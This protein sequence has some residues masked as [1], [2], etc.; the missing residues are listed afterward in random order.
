MW[1]YFATFL[2]FKFEEKAD[3]A[4]QLEQ[5]ITE[6][7]DQHRR[8]KEHA[9]NVIA[10]Q[11][12]QQRQL[13]RQIDRVDKL[14]V[15]ARQA[16]QMADKAAR[17]GDAAKAEEYTRAAETI[18][19]QL[20]EAE[21][22]VESMRSGLLAATAAAD[23]AKGAVS[24]NGLVLQKKLAEKQQLLSRLEQARMQEQMNKA[25][26]SLS[27]TVGQDVPSMD[28]VRDKIDQRFA[29]AK[30]MSEL[31]ETSVESRMLE[32]EAAATNA[33]AQSRLEEIRASLGIAPSEEVVEESSSG[34]VGDVL[35]DGQ[36]TQVATATQ[37]GV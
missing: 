10:G 27:E 4:I 21:S 3:P 16:V 28:E 30:G 26:A 33:G 20:I 8:L 1:R 14:Q 24:T 18:A 13:D 25:M 11:I 12:Q 29:K 37:P 17:S 5:A 34:V 7:Q 22:Q 32:I 23:Q 2:G 9:A 15:N 6:A 31:N 19:T 36:G 35:A